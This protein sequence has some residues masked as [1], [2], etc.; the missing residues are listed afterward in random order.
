MIDGDDA[1][2]A[3]DDLEH[4]LARAALSRG[5][6]LYEEGDV[7]SAL[8]ALETAA[9]TPSVRCTAEAARGTIHLERGEWSAAV[10][11]FIRALRAPVATPV[12][13]DRIHDKLANAKERLAHK[14][15]TAA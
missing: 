14:R 6:R 2:P 1:D 10:D 11:A 9:Q 3:Y 12:E 13:R 4:V 5:V 15:R 7:I 8:S